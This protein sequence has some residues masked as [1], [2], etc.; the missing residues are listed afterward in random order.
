MCA[1]CAQSEDLAD[2]YVPP[3]ASDSW[4]QCPGNCAPAA[5]RP[6]SAIPDAP[7]VMRELAPSEAA[8]A[9]AAPEQDAPW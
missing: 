6:N 8:P 9:S 5:P 3:E 1:A 7:A 4:L 2:L